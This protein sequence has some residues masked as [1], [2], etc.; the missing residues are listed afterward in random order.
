MWRFYNT[1]LPYQLVEGPS[2]LD[3]YHGESERKVRELFT[4]AEAEQ[5]ERGDQSRLHVIMFDG[6]WAKKHFYYFFFC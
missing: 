1:L 4:E 6:M 2:L 5:R 3:K